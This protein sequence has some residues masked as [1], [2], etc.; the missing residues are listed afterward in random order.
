[1]RNEETRRKLEFYLSLH[2]PVTL[3]PGEE[4]TY[5]T[6]I[7]ELPGCMTQADSAEEALKL[8]EEARRSWIEVAYEDGQDIPL[9]RILEDYSGRFV[10][11]IPRSLHRRLARV[12]AGEGVSLNQYVTMLLSSSNAVEE[13]ARKIDKV[14][15]QIEKMFTFPSWPI[16]LQSFS[17]GE[18]VRTKQV[19]T[20][21]AEQQYSLAA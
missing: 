11:R 5:V 3:Y 20:A 21:L 19:A 9:P 10:L 18:S 1:M 7:Q 14:S 6:E 2:Y 12:A 15:S 13:V 17:T 16:V 4:N 8:I